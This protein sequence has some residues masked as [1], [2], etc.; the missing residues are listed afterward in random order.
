MRATCSPQ[1]LSHVLLLVLHMRQHIAWRAVYAGYLSPLQRKTQKAMLCKSTVYEHIPKL[2]IAVVAVVVPVAAALVVVVAVVVVAVV[3]AAAAVV[4]VAV[5]VVVAAV[6][7]VTAVA[8]RVVYPLPTI[9]CSLRK[10][11]VKILIIFHIKNMKQGLTMSFTAS[12]ATE[13]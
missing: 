5:A 7:V 10:R 2:E 8:V 3:V 1:D 13:I 12:I 9:F 4:A 6:V 11:E